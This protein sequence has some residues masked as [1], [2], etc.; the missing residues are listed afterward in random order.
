MDV[1]LHLGAHRTGS[2]TLQRY[3]KR[4]EDNLAKMATAFWGLERTRNGLFSGL[5]GHPDAVT[6]EVERRARRSGGVIHLQLAALAQKGTH[7]L[8]VS[9]ENMIGGPRNNLR[10]EQLYGSAQGRLAR[11]AKAFGG[12]VT[13]V[14]LSIRSYDTYWASV[15]AF[16]VAGGHRMPGTATLDR[17]VTQP[18]RWRDLVQVIAA[19]FPHAQIVVWPFE[20]FVGQPEWQLS[21]L[22][23]APLT[24]PT[25]DRRIWCNPSPTRVQLREVLQDRNDPHLADLPAG[26]GRW[27]PFQPHHIVA[28]RAQYI[29]ELAWL[30]A[31][32]DGLAQYIESAGIHP[33]P[34]TAEEGQT[35]DQRKGSLGQ[36]G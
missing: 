11:Y 34:M 3:L 30:R 26:D 17:L 28:L 21:M 31:G 14:C 10:C 27:Q 4:N 36:T 12:S 1:I 32:A 24:V 19:A 16:G 22:L 20:A 35:H 6:H 2:T 23:D 13:R 15:L 33:R 9:D 25:R 7:A 29:Q 8:I 18:R 5:T